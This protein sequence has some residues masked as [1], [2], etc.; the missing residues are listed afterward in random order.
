MKAEIITIGDELLIGQVIDTNS[1]WIGEQLSLA[2][3][4]VGYKSAVSDD[5][6]E[7]IRA[8]DAA[9]RRSDIIIITGGLGPTKDDITKKTLAEYFDMKLVMN[10]SVLEDVRALF[11]RFGRPLTDLNKLQ[12]M[13]P[14]GCRV[15]PNKN[16][17]APG[18]WF[19]RDN[20][21]YISMPGVPFEMKSMMSDFVIPQ[22]KATFKL[23]FIYHRTILTHGIG[24]SF[25]AE[26]I[27]NWENELAADGL[28]LAYLPSPGM[29][30]L[31]I[32][33]AGMDA[34]AVKSL[35][36]KHE[37]KLMPLISHYFFG[38]DQDTLESVVGRLMTEKHKTLAIA[39]SCTGGKIS[40]MITSVPG[41]SAYFTG[42]VIA[43]DNAVKIHTLQVSEQLIQEHGAVSEPVAMA[44]AEGVRKLFKTD[45]AV[46]TTGI[47]GP[48]GGSPEKPVG[49]VWI[50]ISVNGQTSAKLYQFGD[51][52]ER[53]ILRASLTALSLIRK[54]LI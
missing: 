51:N 13:V 2:G 49:A 48:D 18:M 19:E 5:E 54:A 3:I 52:R 6:Q 25:L 37:E 14:E 38:Y 36:A 31:R 15:I 8:L 7:I 27:E 39:E 11:E 28:K 44:M 9:S 10:E 42:S 16:G 47:A 32:S 40:S 30:R 35:V 1:A 41:S 29:V 4:R 21:V 43:Y 23:P 26:K 24:E 22:L 33:G 17:T 34:T 20:R 50:A 46:A 53:N 12:A 45:I